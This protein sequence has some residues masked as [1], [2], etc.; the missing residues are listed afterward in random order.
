MR[1]S[2]EQCII[3]L[4]NVEQPCNR[5]RKRNKREGNFIQDVTEYVTSV[6]NFGIVSKNKAGIYSNAA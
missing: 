5:K 1:Q 2:C 6:Q 4:V 3:K